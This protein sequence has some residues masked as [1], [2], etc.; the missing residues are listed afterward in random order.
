LLTPAKLL[1]HTDEELEYLAQLVNQRTTWQITGRKGA[2]DGS[3]DGF[4]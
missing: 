3:S 1:N 2:K 4:Y